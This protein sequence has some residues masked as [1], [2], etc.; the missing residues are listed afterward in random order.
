[1]QIAERVIEIISDTE[2][3]NPKLRAIVQHDKDEILKVV[4]HTKLFCSSEHIS[5]SEAFFHLNLI[6][7]QQH[8]PNDMLRVIHCLLWM[9][10]LWL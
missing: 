1:M 8:L 5:V 4:F 2:K 9:G 10:F 7:W 3:Q 6:R